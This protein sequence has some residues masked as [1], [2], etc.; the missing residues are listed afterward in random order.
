MAQQEP[1]R[2]TGESLPAWS[3]PAH[4]AQQ[5]AIGVEWPEQVTRDWAWGGSTGEGVRVCI[6]D[7]GVEAGHP[8]VGELEGAVAIKRGEGDQTIVEE[9]TEGDLCGHGTGCAG[10]VRSLAPE[11][12]L[13]SV[14]VLGA[15]FKGSGTILL[16]GLRWAVEQGFDVINM[17]LSTTKQQI[18]TFLHE[19]ADTAYFRRTVLVASAHNMPVESYPWRFSSVISVGSHEESDPRTFFYNPSPP[20]EFFARGVGVE[21]AWLGG[22]RFPSSTGVAGWVLVTRQPLVIEDLAE[23]PRHAREAAESTGFVPKGLMAVPL[24]HEDRALGVLE[25]L[26]RPQ[27]A[28]FSLQEMELLGL[29]ANEAAIAL[30]LLQRAREARAVL[31]EEGGESVRAMREVYRN[32]GLRRLQLAWAGSIIGTWAFTV[33]LAVYAYDHGGASAV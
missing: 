3:L 18:A 30:D 12:S 24:L 11:C 14:R 1:A 33:A 9:D 29:F 15:G 20:V 31:Q 17:S 13:F 28:A 19:L 4:A 6:L 23:D 2:Y 32:R 16:G 25:V 7:S 27:E 26:D 10:I 5:I 21:I 22:R 8:L